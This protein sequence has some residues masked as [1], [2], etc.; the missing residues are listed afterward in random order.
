MFISDQKKFS[1]KNSNIF[2]TKFE[3]FTNK[4]RRKTLQTKIEYTKEERN[5]CAN[6][7]H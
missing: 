5:H 3:Q 4:F 7:Y 2:S 6:I 1:R